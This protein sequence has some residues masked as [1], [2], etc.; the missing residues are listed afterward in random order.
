M[1]S[2]GTGSSEGWLTLCTCSQEFRSP[3][4][5]QIQTW[6]RIQ[7][8]P[9]GRQWFLRFLPCL[10][11]IVKSEDIYKKKMSLLSCKYIHCVGAVEWQYL[12]YL[13]SRA[14]NAGKMSTHSLFLSPHISPIKQRKHICKHTCMIHPKDSRGPSLYIFN[15]IFTFACSVAYSLL[16][17]EEKTMVSSGLSRSF[18]YIGW[19]RVIWKRCKGLACHSLGTVTGFMDLCA[20]G[21]AAE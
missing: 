13:T 6:T 5:Y 16:M 11:S 10:T 20:S 4:E 9:R 1:A 2:A 21:E 8:S 19:V 3:L 15:Q 17:L 18:V 14:T 12:C 7:N